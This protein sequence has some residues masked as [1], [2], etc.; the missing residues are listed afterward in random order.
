MRFSFVFLASVPSLFVPSVGFA[1]GSAEPVQ[2]EGTFKR[3]SSSLQ[4]LTTARSGP[5]AIVEW[6]PAD[7]L[8]QRVRLS[9][10]Y[11][12]VDGFAFGAAMEYQKQNLPKWTYAT[13]AMGLT[14]TQYF[15]SQALRGP[16]VRG[17]CDVFGSFFEINRKN[18]REQSIYGLNMGLDLGYRFQLGSRITGG[19]AY[20]V[21]RQVPDFFSSGKSPANE[22]YLDHS[23][24]WD[25]R[26]QVSLGV[27]L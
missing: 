7:L 18:A 15:E 23:R 9:S 24:L 27:T 25:V 21:R 5:Y 4:S 6:N 13:A 14:A 8:Q 1:I 26:V 17:E 12:V 2:S 16:F 11:V 3:L 22:D 10:E 20:G 19:A